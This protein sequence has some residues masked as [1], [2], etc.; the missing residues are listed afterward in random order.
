LEEEDRESRVTDVSFY[1]QYM[2]TLSARWQLGLDANIRYYSSDEGIGT[3]YEIHALAGPQLSPDSSIRQWR[4]EHTLNWTSTLQ[5]LLTW[6]ASS[7]LKI[8]F[9]LAADYR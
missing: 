4:E 1:P 3:R 8:Q 9:R 5:S 7:R 2:R 6:T